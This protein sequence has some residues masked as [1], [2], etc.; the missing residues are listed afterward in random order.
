MRV[1]RG[2]TKTVVVNPLQERVLRGLIEAGGALAY[3]QV[4][5]AATG[6]RWDDLGSLDRLRVGV[7]MRGLEKRHLLEMSRQWDGQLGF[8]RPTV[9]RVTDLGRTAVP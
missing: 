5:R 7:S 1:K 6:L 8:G 3:R 4:F 2:S 9:V